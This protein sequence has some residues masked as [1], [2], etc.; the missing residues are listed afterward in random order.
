[1]EHHR[2]LLELLSNVKGKFMLSINDHPAV[3]E[4][5]APFYMEEVET[6]YTLSKQVTGRQPA[7]ELIITN[8]IPTVLT[9]HEQKQS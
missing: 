4:W 8:Y 7:K 1:M 5:Y 3:R 9:G 6:R 2:K